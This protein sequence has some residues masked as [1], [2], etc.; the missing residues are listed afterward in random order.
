MEN[1]SVFEAHYKTQLSSKL[2][3]HRFSW[4]LYAYKPGWQALNTRI[5][6]IQTTGRSMLLHV[7]NIDDRHY[8]FYP[9]IYKL[10]TNT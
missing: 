4:P 5:L 9:Y 3:N 1:K 2:D 10:D 8:A 7:H 6:R